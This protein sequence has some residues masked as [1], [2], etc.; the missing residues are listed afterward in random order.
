MRSATLNFGLEKQ[1]LP[2][3]GVGQLERR[4]AF[5]LAALEALGGSVGSQSVRANSG[6]VNHPTHTSLPSLHF[7]FAANFCPSTM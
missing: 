4:P 2:A 3:D 6:V 1:I 7:A 5:S